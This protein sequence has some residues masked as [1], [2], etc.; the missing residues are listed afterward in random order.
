MKDVRTILAHA[1]STLMSVSKDHDLKADKL[2]ENA[3][4]ALCS[5]LAELSELTREALRRALGHRVITL[6]A[7]GKETA[8]GEYE[9]F[10]IGPCETRD[11]VLGF[12]VFEAG[13]CLVQIVTSGGIVNYVTEAIW[14]D[15]LWEPTGEELKAG[16]A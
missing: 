11:E 5:D 13:D 16:T 14:L 10:T 4:E 8:P 2:D 15:G 7:I 12:D 9:G 6:Y 1:F 3:L